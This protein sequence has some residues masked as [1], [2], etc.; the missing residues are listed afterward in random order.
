MLGTRDASVCSQRQDYRH[1]PLMSPL[2]KR[3]TDFEF[4]LGKKNGS[5]QSSY[6]ITVISTKYG[7]K[8]GKDERHLCTPAPWMGMCEASD[9][10]RKRLADCSFI[11]L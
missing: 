11:F 9:A 1:T 8:E 7:V 6:H 5:V 4:H 3:L 10:F 2:L